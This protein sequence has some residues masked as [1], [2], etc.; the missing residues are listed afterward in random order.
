MEMLLVIVV[1]ACIIAA[2]WVVYSI[3]II[4]IIGGIVAVIVL[5]WAISTY[6]FL[7]RLKSRKETAWSNILVQL[8]RR[9]E[10]IAN[11]VEAVKGYSKHEKEILV[12]VAAKR[13][14]AAGAVTPH[15]RTEAEHAL[16]RSLHKLFIV[17]EN[18]PDLKASQNFLYLQQELSIV[19]S[20]L[21]EARCKFND[22]VQEYNILIRSFPTML[23]AQ[24][25]SMSDAEYFDLDEPEERE[26]PRI[27]F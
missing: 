17:A 7:V 23:I 15:A 16:M 24:M 25:L 1:V 26:S 27:R 12:E 21:Q 2:C 14:V 19:E 8:K 9:H 11:L 20:S 4:Q 10:F 3:G 13:A 18:Y 5:L 22:T 6:N